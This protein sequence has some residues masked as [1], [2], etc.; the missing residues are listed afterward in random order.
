VSGLRQALIQSAA[1][2]EQA[3]DFQTTGGVRLILILFRKTSEGGKTRSAAAPPSRWETK[4]NVPSTFRAKIPDFSRFDRTRD[5]CGTR[6]PHASSSSAASSASMEKLAGAAQLD[7]GGIPTRDAR[8]RAPHDGIVTRSRS[9]ASSLASIGR[10]SQA[11]GARRAR[12][13]LLCLVR[14]PKNPGW[15]RARSAGRGAG[16]AQSGLGIRRDRATYG[17]LWRS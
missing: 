4:K 17:L 5:M 11:H 15:R 3:R 13:R 1:P 10:A 9:R 16:F 7:A 14:P 6:K 2:A 8:A 12:R